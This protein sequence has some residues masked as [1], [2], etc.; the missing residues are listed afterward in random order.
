ME[1]VDASSDAAHAFR[2]ESAALENVQDVRLHTEGDADEDAAPH[3]AMGLS[4]AE[5]AGA[6]P[7][8]NTAAGDEAN[9]AAGDDDE[10][11]NMDLPARF[12][13]ATNAAG[14]TFGLGLDQFE[15][16]KAPVAKLA[17]SSVRYRRDGTP[18]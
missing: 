8:A 2:P 14:G 12:M 10:R 13:T 17:R 3:G 4:I 9:T 15:L 16:P 18:R 5:L 7:E 6:E 1:P 11:E